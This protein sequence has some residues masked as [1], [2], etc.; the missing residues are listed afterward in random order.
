ME[1]ILE[2]KHL[3]KTFS[4]ADGEALK[5]ISLEVERGEMLGLI[6]ESGSGKTT[7]LRLIAGL[8]SPTSGSIYLNGKK[9]VG[10]HTF[11][12]PEKREIG[13]V[14]QEYALFPHMT[15]EKNISY[16]LHKMDPAKA[17][18]RLFEVLE[19]VNM[20]ELASRYSHELSGGQ[21]QRAALARALAPNPSII[22][23]DEP[24]SHLDG[25]L[26]DQMREELRTILKTSGTTALFVTH[27][28]MD[29]LS[30]SDRIALLQKGMLQQVGEPREL[31]EKPNNLY[32]ANFLGKVNLIRGY[33]SSNGILTDFG[34]FP[35]SSKFEDG[36][37]VILS[38]R[39]EHV[40]LGICPDSDLKGVLFHSSYQGDHQLVHLRPSVKNSRMRII[41]KMPSTY[42]VN[43]GEVV[44]FRVEASSINLFPANGVNGH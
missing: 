44:G 14:F 7:L 9:I 34:T 26:K 28:T 19:W 22:L 1:A 5:D 15:I 38:V 29:A 21:Q 4:R 30:V 32:T 35:P 20:A 37:E 13:M 43:I 16:G 2:I 18:K 40:R 6:G 17:R 31:Y 33:C 10:Q 8:E 42:M 25:V 36:E 23:L 41:L 11:V 3:T 12:P 27:D 24:F 39:P